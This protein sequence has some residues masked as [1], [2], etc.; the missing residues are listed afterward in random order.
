MK[1][2]ESI[3]LHYRFFKF[4]S[5][6]PGLRHLEFMEWQLV[7]DT[8]WEF[9][10]V[11]CRTIILLQDAIEPG[12]LQRAREKGFQMLCYNPETWRVFPDVIAEDIAHI[13]N[14]HPESHF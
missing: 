12:K 7:G 5:T 10:S 4:L 3:R 14:Y 13:S 2:L 1:P 6:H 9:V 11:R 8:T